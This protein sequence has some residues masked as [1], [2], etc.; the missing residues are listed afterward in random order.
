MFLPHMFIFLNGIQ[1]RPTICF[2]ESD[3]MFETYL[4]HL[5]HL[6]PCL[7]KSRHLVKQI[8]MVTSATDMGVTTQS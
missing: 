7:Q 3:D 1:K 5:I 2:S 4:H 8:H 6:M